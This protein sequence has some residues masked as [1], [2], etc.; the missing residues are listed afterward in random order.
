VLLAG[1]AVPA[2][3]AL[4]ML[5]ICCV[6]RLIA[7]EPRLGRVLL[8]ALA[9]VLALDPLAG[10]AAG[11]WLSFLA[12]AV[13]AATGGRAAWPWP[14][15]WS[16]LGPHL[17]VAVGLAPLLAFLGEAQARVGVPANLLAIPWVGCVSTPLALLGALMELVLPG[18]GAWPWW[19][20]AWSL[21]PVLPFL[22]ALAALDAGGWRPLLVDGQSR[23]AFALLCLLLLLPRG[24]PIRLAALSLFLALLLPREPRP[25][26]AGA[27]ELEVFDVGQGTALAVRTARHLLVFDTGPPLGARLDPGRDIIAARLIAEGRRRVD[28]LMLSHGDLDHV[29]GTRGLLAALAVGGLDTATPERFADLR[30]PPAPCRTGAFWHWDE[31][32]FRVLHPPGV[33]R[34]KGNDASCVLLVSGR[35]GRLLLPGDIEERAEYRLLRSAREALAADVVVLPHHGSRS[36]STPAF[37][38]AT[39]ARVAISTTGHGNRHGHPDPRVVRRWQR[40]G[41]V[42]LDTARD[43]ALRVLVGPGGL[44]IRAERRDAPRWW[45][46]GGA[47]GETDVN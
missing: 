46:A 16:W 34:W 6:L 17:A 28:C 2:R 20:A 1:N 37:V 33:G 40:A 32:A 24:L 10:L 9:V 27:F 30:P 36:S 31:V 42:H 21:A 12:V 22:D 26:P 7:A 5:G 25:L 41:A 39:A 43:G 45:R 14:A 3:R 29:S 13:L 44:E 8:V 11:T 4:L 47:G 35:W 23:I 15:P 18:G 38:R 19:L